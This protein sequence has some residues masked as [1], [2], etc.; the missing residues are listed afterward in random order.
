VKKSLH[1]Q[2]DITTS[3]GQKVPAEQGCHMLNRK[4]NKLINFWQKIYENGKM[5]GNIY[6]SLQNGNFSAILIS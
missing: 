3:L 6:F 2:C 5:F 1:L 4:Y